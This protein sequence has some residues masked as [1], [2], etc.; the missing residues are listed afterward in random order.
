MCTFEFSV[1]SE[2]QEALLLAVTTTKQ[3]VGIRIFKD[4]Y[5]SDQNGNLDDDFEAYIDRCIRDAID[6]K[7]E[8]EVGMHDIENDPQIVKNPKSDHI[9]LEKLLELRAKSKM[10]IHI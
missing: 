8:I 2:F 4:S 7:R 10:R 3:C 6:I 1:S 5:V 9:D